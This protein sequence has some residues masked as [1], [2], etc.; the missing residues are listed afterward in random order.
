VKT[1]AGIQ[2]CPH[3]AKP[4]M[5]TARVCPETGRGI[6]H[7]LHRRDE[8]SHPLLGVILDGKYLVRRLIGQ[9][10]LGTVFEGENLALKR[11]VA[12]KVVRE[13]S[14]EDALL[15]LRREAEIV[16]SL[17]HANICDIYDFGVVAEHGPYIVTQRLHGETLA[18]RFKWHARL[19]VTETVE[20]ISQ[21]LSGL[22]VAHAR[23][24]I[25]RDLKPQNI[26]LVERVG[27]APLVKLLDFGLAR[28]LTQVVRLTQQGKVLGTPQYMAPEQLAGDNLGPAADLFSVGVVTYEMLSGRHPFAASSLQEVQARVL[29]D[30][31]TPLA[32]LVRDLPP[33][34]EAVVMCALEKRPER[35]YRDA[36]AMQLDLLRALPAR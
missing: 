30:A 33:Q 36:Y 4:H 9:G 3:C 29:R 1:P 8:A 2:W 31:P 20:I 15:R 22:Q 16:A 35:R 7:D 25:H 12:I 28:D 26:F 23:H 21:V 32:K 11:E 34:V 19:R 17:Q 24:I 13:P 27:C 5:L 10:G 18:G 6:D 14:R